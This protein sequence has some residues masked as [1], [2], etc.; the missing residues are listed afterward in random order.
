MTLPEPGIPEARLRAAVALR[1]RR[2]SR[3]RVA[4]EIGLSPRGLW[5]FLEGSRPHP[6][7][8]LKLER[9]YREVIASRTDQDELS[10]AEALHVLVG[11]I[12]PE[13]YSEALAQLVDFV[14]GLYARFHA[15]VPEEIQPAEAGPATERSAEHKS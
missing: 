13:H 6:K 10:S 4:A 11:G 1:I 2:S 15:S 8:R 3:R 12:S 14:T 5:K 9:W 7:T